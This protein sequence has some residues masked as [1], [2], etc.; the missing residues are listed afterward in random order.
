MSQLVPNERP[1]LHRGGGGAKNDMSL[2]GGVV[3]GTQDFAPPTPKKSKSPPWK[4]IAIG[5]AVVGA[6]LAAFLI[7]TAGGDK[8]QAAAKSVAAVPAD[9]ALVAPDAKAAVAVVDAGAP[10]AG[11]A[12][13]VVAVAGD[14]DAISGVAPIIKPAKKKL[15]RKTPAKKTGKKKPAAKRK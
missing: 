12:P 8:P 15:V 7:A 3:V 2:W 1:V 13:T 6:G 4:W 5:L 10:D 14:V 9:A 11:A